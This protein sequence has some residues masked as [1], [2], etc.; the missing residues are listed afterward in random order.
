[1]PLQ[2]PLLILPFLILSSSLAGH[3]AAAEAM[4]RETKNLAGTWR[5]RLDPDDV[6]HSQNW[7][8]AEFSDEVRLP[9]STDENHVGTPTPPDYRGKDAMQWL[10]R[11]FKYVGPAWYQREV[12]IP[13]AWQGRRVVLFLERCHWE[14]QVWV[15]GKLQG[16][17]NSLCV[18]HEYDLSQSLTPGRHRLTICV[19]NRLKIDVGPHGHSVSEHT[20]TNWNGIVGRIELWAA[21]PVWIEAIQVYPDVKQKTARVK[22]T[23]VNATDKPLA[24]DFVVEARP[25]EDRSGPP[26][27][28]V[29][30]PVTCNVGSTT[31]DLDLPMGGD[32]R[33]WD[34]FAPNLYELTASL[35]QGSRKQVVFG[36]R[37]FGTHGTQFAVNGRTTF[38]RGTLECCIFP[39][40]GYP[41]MDVEA[42]MRI[43]RILKSYGLNHLRFH[44]WCPPEAAFV[45]ADRVGVMFHVETPM[46]VDGKISDN[47]TRVEFVR[48]EF[49]RILDTYGNHPSFAMMCL[50]NELGSGDDQFL[51]ELVGSGKQRD[52]RHLYTCAT[53]PS[54]PKPLDDYYVT[55]QTPKGWV[56]GQGRFYDQTPCTQ[57]DYRGALEGIK[58][59]VVSHEIGQWTIYPN[60]DEIPKYTGVVWPRNFEL[61]RENLASHH[62]LDQARDFFLAS[63]KLMVLLYREEI[64]S[65]LRTPGF[66]GFQLLDL[67]DFPG[68][69]TALVGTLDPFWDSKGL[70]EPAEFRRYCGPI[71]PL[72]RMSKRTWTT[73]ETFAAAVEVAHYGPEDLQGVSPR[74]TIRD[75]DGRSLASGQ[76]TKL[77]VAAG[78]L[79]EL[80]RLDVPLARLPAPAKLRV[81]VS[82]D[83]TDLANDWEFWVYPAQIDTAAPADV[84]V[85]ASWSE[86]KETLADGRRVLF[87]P[88]LSS[89]PKSARTGRFTPVFWSPLWFKTQTSTMGT[90]CDPAH[91]ALAQFPTEYHSNWQWWDLVLH[92]RPLSL[93]ATPPEFRPVVQAIDNFTSNE[94]LGLVFEAAVGPGRLMVSTIDLA[95]HLNTR[96]VAR[97]LRHSLLSYMASDRFQPQGKLE[98][99]TV[100]KLLSD[101]ATER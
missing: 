29:S 3:A 95:D 19:D 71:V 69:G 11:R 75:A 79:R 80:G 98:P 68:Q 82:L 92:S 84:V 101:K 91:P 7:A 37:Q 17:Q 96:P 25:Q 97:Q 81:E 27:A 74:W 93:E 94:K 53:R 43:C 83:G 76:L 63:G 62:M 73:D 46:W 60:F 15:D 51:W 4:P 6:G 30:Q 88:S 1:M 59:P 34:E 85:T 12:E 22:A 9:G 39:L 48:N 65:A 13:A 21:E 67:H 2:R 24:T 10:T 50:G 77:D 52:S 14:T 70:I 40:T 86:A 44:S 100:E 35:G 66:G 32:V 90:L 78:G 26:C 31:V 23:V 57:I 49:N 99:D 42:W 56:R 18:P 72:L 36:M 54:E 20:Q 38:L 61:I 16:S 55:H 45:A 89:L 64:E 58:L 41:S 5:F 47:P 28:R 8:D 33:L 87:L